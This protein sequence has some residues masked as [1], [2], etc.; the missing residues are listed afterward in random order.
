MVAL[1]SQ[2]EL[3]SRLRQWRLDASFKGLRSTRFPAGF[4]LLLKDLSPLLL[5]PANPSVPLSSPVMEL[6]LR[7]Q[8][9]LSM[10][11]SMKLAIPFLLLASLF[12]PYAL[13][14]RYFKS[15]IF[16][17]LLDLYFLHLFYFV[18]AKLISCIAFS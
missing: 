7:S 9:L 6:G 1:S 16:R 8:T 12:G 13:I 2:I 18:Y 3:L 17:A 11:V 10:S 5:P 15:H 4:F 14:L